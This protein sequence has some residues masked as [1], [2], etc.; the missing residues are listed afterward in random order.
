MFFFATTFLSIFESL[1]YGLFAISCGLQGCMGF[2]TNNFF[3]IGMSYHCPIQRCGTSTLCCKILCQIWFYVTFYCFLFTLC[4]FQ[5]P[6]FL[7]WCRKVS[8]I[9]NGIILQKKLFFPF[10]LKSRSSSP[11]S[12]DLRTSQFPLSSFFWFSSLSF[13]ISSFVSSNLIN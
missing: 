1:F 6:N 10:D 4:K 11:T 3:H 12:N 8:F 5:S 2:P 13:I 7:F 9:L